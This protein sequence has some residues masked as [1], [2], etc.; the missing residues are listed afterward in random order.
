PATAA[1]VHHTQ[2]VTL[3]IPPGARAGTRS[4]A[5]SKPLFLAGAAGWR[6]AATDMGLTQALRVDASGRIE[7][8]PQFQARLTFVGTSNVRI[9]P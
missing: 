4:D 7:V 5:L 6:K 8:T 3:L 9:V 2:A 1:P